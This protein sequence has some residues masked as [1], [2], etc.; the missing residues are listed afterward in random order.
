MYRA[1][2]FTLPIFPATIAQIATIISNSHTISNELPGA[3]TLLFL[4]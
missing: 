1:K 3:L 2:D 4:P